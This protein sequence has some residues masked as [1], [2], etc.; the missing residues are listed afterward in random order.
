MAESTELGR[1]EENAS[2]SFNLEVIIIQV[3]V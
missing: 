1:Y 2:D 3:L